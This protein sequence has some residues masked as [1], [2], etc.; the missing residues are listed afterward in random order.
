MVIDLCPGAPTIYCLEQEGGFRGDGTNGP[1]DGA[2]DKVEAV[3]SLEVH[4]GGELRPLLSTVACH[5]ETSCCCVRSQIVKN[6]SVVEIDEI[7]ST[8][9]LRERQERGT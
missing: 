8:C 2:R 1:A 6:P 4:T 9:T 3:H 5:V 7:R